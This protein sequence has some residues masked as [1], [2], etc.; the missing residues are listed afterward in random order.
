MSIAKLTPAT[1]KPDEGVIEK[2]ESALRHAKAGRLREVIILGSWI[3]GEYFHNASFKEGPLFV[4]Y[5]EMAK[6]KIISD[7]EKNEDSPESLD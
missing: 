1:L 3:G 2:L 7:M 5:I 4:G 6:W